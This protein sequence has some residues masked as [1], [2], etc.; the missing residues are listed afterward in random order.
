MCFFQK[1]KS[2][3]RTSDLNHWWNLNSGF[4]GFLYT[5]SWYCATKIYFNDGTISWYL[6]FQ[7]HGLNS[8][9]HSRGSVRQT[10]LGN[11]KIHVEMMISLVGYMENIWQTY[12]KKSI[13]FF[14]GLVF[15]QLLWGMKQFFLN[16]TTWPYFALKGSKVWECKPAAKQLGLPATYY[17]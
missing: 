17:K 7:S 15:S 4:L 11:S 6:L 13:I 12:G 3:Q 9:L 2:P 16:Q 14:C 10:S 1:Q 8:N 5:I